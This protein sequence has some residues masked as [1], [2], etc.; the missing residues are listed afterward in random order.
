VPR[1]LYG[2]TAGG[3]QSNITFDVSGSALISN[4]T[5]LVPYVVGRMLSIL[6]IEY[7]HS[8]ALELIRATPTTTCR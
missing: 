4:F 3:S 5:G 1:P 2:R 8:S 6:P 7:R